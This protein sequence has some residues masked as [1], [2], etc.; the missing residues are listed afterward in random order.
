MEYSYIKEA[1]YIGSY[2]INCVFEDG[3]SGLFDFSNYVKRGGVFSC[4][5]NEHY[6]KKISLINGVLS[7]GNGELDIAPET[8]YHQV[9]KRPLP[10]WMK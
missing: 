6:A 4:L 7:W 10:R 3:L 1:K 9:T 8:V 5:Q 2:K